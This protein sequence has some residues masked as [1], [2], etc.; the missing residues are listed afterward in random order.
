MQ[1]ISANLPVAARFE[2]QGRVRTRVVVQNYPVKTIQA[3]V[4]SRVWKTQLELMY[5]KSKTALYY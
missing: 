1:V 5:K 2:I 3:A 4:K